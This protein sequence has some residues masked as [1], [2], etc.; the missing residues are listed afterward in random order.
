MFRNYLSTSNH[1]KKWRT[2]NKSI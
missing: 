1:Y 2:D